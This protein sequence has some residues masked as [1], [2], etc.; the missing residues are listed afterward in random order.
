MEFY[1]AE[2]LAYSMQKTIANVTPKYDFLRIAIAVVFAIMLKCL[3]FL[4]KVHEILSLV[5]LDTL[6]IFMFF[7]LPGPNDRC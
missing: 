1:L 5:T 4:L 7:L 6:Y 2:I 3:Q